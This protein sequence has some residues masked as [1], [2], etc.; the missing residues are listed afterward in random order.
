MS[1]AWF[2]RL[3]TAATPQS[4]ASRRAAGLRRR[5]TVE[6]LEG[7]QMLSTLT[8]TTAVDNGSNTAPTTGS[9]RAAILQADAQP[10]GTLTTIDFKI[11]TGPQ[12]ISP[13]DAL[14]Q[15]TRPV[16]IDGTTQSGYAGTPIIDVDGTSAGS[17]TTG[18][19]VGGSASGTATAPGVL[20]GVEITDFGG[21]GVSVQ[22]SN[23]NLNTDYIG[24]GSERRCLRQQGQ[25]RLR[26][27]IVQRGE[28]R[29]CQRQHG[30]VDPG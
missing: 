26:G 10:A 20:K 2:R 11:G 6:H 27:R 14:P 29:P 3:R 23:F 21:G 25:W 7:R 5:F 24:L 17:S 18:F 13:P 12:T 28:R 4:I 22:A 19:A 9:L 16:V 15:I 1:T 30:R 8:V